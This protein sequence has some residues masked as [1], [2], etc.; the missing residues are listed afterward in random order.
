LSAE[1][2]EPDDSATDPDGQDQ[3]ESGNKA[4][5]HAQTAPG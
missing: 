2:V 3:K 5:F 1:E 4:A